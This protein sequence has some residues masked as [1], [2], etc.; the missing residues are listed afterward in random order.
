M[1]R[2]SSKTNLHCK[3]KWIYLGVTNKAMQTYFKSVC[4]VN[5]G[6]DSYISKLG[7]GS[8]EPFVG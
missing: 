6:I 8:E 1:S 7:R 2:W 3:K 4:D 5:S